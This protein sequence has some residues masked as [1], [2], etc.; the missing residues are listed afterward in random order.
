[1]KGKENLLKEKREHPYTEKCLYSNPIYTLI[2]DKIKMK[3]KEKM[4][5]LKKDK[6][7]KSNTP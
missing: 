3:T 1:M 6:N 4:K 2:K 5:F 7:N